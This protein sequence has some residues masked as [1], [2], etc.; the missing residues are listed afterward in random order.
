MKNESMNK[1]FP[2]NLFEDLEIESP[3]EQPEVFLATLMYIMRC[4][5]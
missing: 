4:I 2:Y 1:P 3:A 5:A